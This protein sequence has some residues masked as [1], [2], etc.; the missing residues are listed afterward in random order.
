MS[1]FVEGGGDRLCLAWFVFCFGYCSWCKT[2][3]GGL[4]IHVKEP[5]GVLWEVA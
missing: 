3:G 5:G 2:R 4:L 1:Q